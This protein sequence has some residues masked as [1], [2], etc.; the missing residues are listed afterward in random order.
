MNVTQ[1]IMDS[2]T[3]VLKSPDNEALNNLK[4]SLK[5]FKPNEN[6]TTKKEQVEPAR[7]DL[8]EYKNQGRIVNGLV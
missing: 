7:T 5:A 8:M 3:D 1:Q 2:L 4:T 6:N